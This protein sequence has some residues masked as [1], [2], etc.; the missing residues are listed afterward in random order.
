MKRFFSFKWWLVIALMAL[1]ALTT[2]NAQGMSGPQAEE[3]ETNAVLG[4]G[5]TYQ[6]YMENGGAPVNGLCDFR[7]SL[8]LPNNIQM[9]VTQTKTGVLVRKGSFTV[10]LNEND[11]FGPEAYDYTLSPALEIAVRCPSGLGNYTTLSPRQKLTAVP[12]A[13]GLPYFQ[14]QLNNTS[15]NMVG[16]LS[17]VRQGVVGATI[18]GGGAPPI[19]ENG[20]SI[21]QNNEVNSNYSTVGGGQNN[22]A[23]SSVDPVN[24]NSHATV[25]GGRE[26]F[27]TAFYSAIAGGR[28]NYASG[29]YSAIG[30]GNSNTASAY[31]A[32]VPGGW[33]NQANGTRSFAAGHNAIANHN[34]A[35]VWADDQANLNFVSTGVNEFSVRATGGVRLVTGIDGNNGNPTAGVKLNP[36]GSSWSSLSDREAK[37]NFATLDGR[38][39]LGRLAA[40]PISAWSYKAEGNSIRHIGPMA[41]DFYA[42]FGLG[43]DQRYITSIDSEG[44]ALAAIQGLNSLVVEQQDRIAALQSREADQEK[45]LAAL[46]A[47]LAQGIPSN[48]F[49]SARETSVPWLELMIGLLVMVSVID[50]LRLKPWMRGKH[51]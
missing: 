23:G 1:I 30:G 33:N 40:V 3:N 37:T 2:G 17:A 24:V 11:Q 10:V 7:F 46:E 45:R 34:G 38:E 18:S 47:Q 27:A 5:F 29:W 15:P 16:G 13:Y 12:F 25:G 35:F 41:Q 21:L 32:T 20:L 39:V 9:G 50:R 19:F 51:S 6:G 36:A 26:N 42:A 22:F 4:A 31:G 14:V 48:G 43:D 28:S 44:V 8:W 49:A